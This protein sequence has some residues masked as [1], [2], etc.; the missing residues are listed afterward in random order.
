MQEAGL[1]SDMELEADEIGTIKRAH[2]VVENRLHHVLD[3]IF[4]KDRPPAEN[5][6]T[7]WH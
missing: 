7:I 4:R 3:D 1:I 5:L 2:Q 6:E